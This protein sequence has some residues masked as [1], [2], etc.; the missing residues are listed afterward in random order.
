MR[1]RFVY[2]AALLTSVHCLLHLLTL[3]LGQT[4]GHVRPSFFTS[5]EVGDGLGNLSKVGTD[6]FGGVTIT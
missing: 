3:E 1:V 4:C 5:D 2:I 6:L